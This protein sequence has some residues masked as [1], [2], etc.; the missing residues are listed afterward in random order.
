MTNKLTGAV[1]LG[2]GD[3]VMICVNE[4]LQPGDV[5]TALAS[6]RRH[7]PGIKFVLVDTVSGVLVQRKADGEREDAEQGEREGEEE[8]EG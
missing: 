3:T 8:E 5:D 4:S 6:L 7:L 2:H 1:L